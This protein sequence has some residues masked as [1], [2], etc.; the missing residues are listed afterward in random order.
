MPHRAAGCLFIGSDMME[1]GRRVLAGLLLVAG[2]LAGGAS[3]GGA[4]DTGGSGKKAKPPKTAKAPKGADS[5]KADGPPKQK[6]LPAPPLFASETPLAVTL[7]TNIKQIKKDKSADAPWRTATLSYAGTD[8]KTVTL[9]VRI[10]TRGVWRLKHCDYPPIR[11]KVGDKAGKGTL[12]ADIDEPKLVTYCRNQDVYEQYVLQEAQ[13]YRM[14]RVLT[15]VSH[16]VRIVRMSYADSATG[17]VEVT[18]YSFLVEDPA[19]VARRAGGVILEQKGAGPDDLDPAASATAFVFQYFIGNTDFSYAGLHNGEVVALADG[20]NLPVSYDF[21]FAGVINATYAGVDPSLRVKRVRDRQ[22]R[23]YCAHQAAY[24]QALALFVA[25]REALSALYRDEI[26]QLLP[27]GKVKQ[28]IGYFDDFYASIATP[29]D[30]Q[31]N[32]Y[33][34]CVK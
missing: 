25:K 6:K 16:K 31:R 5:A 8:G 4:Q 17:Q 1:R 3:A 10:K 30:A 11:I 15:D 2:V 32:L 34:D 7:T 18:R 21:D 20:R 13:I 14:N 27:A 12:F 24:P 33:A 26:G 28:T 19:H 22:F 9:P 29:K 23:G